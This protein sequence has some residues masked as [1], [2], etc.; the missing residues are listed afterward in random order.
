M[1]ETFEPRNPERFGDIEVTWTA[2]ADGNWV[3]CTAT[4]NTSVHFA[5]IT[6]SREADFTIAD[7]AGTLSLGSGGIVTSGASGAY[8]IDESHLVLTATS[9]WTLARALAVS[10]AIADGAFAFGI[11]KELEKA[12]RPKVWLKSGASLVIDETEALISID[13][14]TGSHKSRSG[15]EKNTIFQVNMEAAVEMSR[16]I[17]LRNLGG[18]VIMDFI[19]MKERRHR[20]A[21]YEKMVELMSTD[22]AKNHILPISQL[23]IM[24]MTRQRQQEL[25]DLARSVDAIVVV[26]GLHSANTLHLVELARELKPALHVQTADD[27]DPAWFRN[28]RRIGLTAGAS[29]PDFVIREVQQRLAAL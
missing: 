24:Q 25:L 28:Y 21:I 5:G 7:G 2:D 15:D 13:V 9:I 1:T 14:N 22:K 10:S 12:L 6:F 29:T 19:D 20:N 26:G 18:I 27:V 17:R 8:Q 3:A 16:Q 23:G 11:T 4:I